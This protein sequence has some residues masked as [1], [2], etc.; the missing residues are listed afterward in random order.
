[1]PTILSRRI[2][3][4]ILLPFFMFLFL[5]SQQ[6]TCFYENNLGQTSGTD[7]LCLGAVLSK[8]QARAC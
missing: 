5:E 8:N 3:E 4:V 6:S 1:M 2:S 7:L